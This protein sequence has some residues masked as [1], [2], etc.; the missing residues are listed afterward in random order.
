[1]SSVLD[2]NVTKVLATRRGPNFVVDVDL[3]F[4]IGMTM[5][6]G[7]SGAGKSTLLTC[8]AGVTSPDTGWV[9]IGDRTLTCT[10]AGIALPMH[11]RRIGYL[12]Q[13]LA[14]FPHL[15]VRE[16]VAY[17]VHGDTTTRKEKVERVMDSFGVSSLQSRR[18]HEISGGE[19]Q[20]VALAR[21]LV[22]EPTALLL[23]E[24]MSSLDPDT[25]SAIIDDLRLWNSERRLPVVYVTHDDSE[26]LAMG[27]RTVTM[28]K[29]RVVNDVPSP[30][31]LT[32]ATHDV[33]RVSAVV[34]SIDLATMV[35][36]CRLMNSDI[37]IA[38]Y[39]P[40]STPGDILT[41][42]LNPKISSYDLRTS[43]SS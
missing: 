7:R 22:T 40:G 25:K 1:M 2:V 6:V 8:I 20:R 9:K 35:A 26:V 34:I 28:C 31:V 33:S 32:H 24:P 11:R 27:I 17:G 14:L 29:G 42:A 43:L 13:D 36:R 23:D 10:K 4:D 12:F 15:S 5:I 19:Q 41:I 30:H 21:T 18:P 39:R 37:V 16:N 3:T 38:V